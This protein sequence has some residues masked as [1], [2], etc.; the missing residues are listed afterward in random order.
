M[1]EV[2]SVSTEMDTTEC[3]AVLQCLQFLFLEMKFDRICMKLGED[4]CKHMRAQCNHRLVSMQYNAT[5]RCDMIS[6]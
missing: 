1:H 6:K 5:K 3:I 4:I 2:S